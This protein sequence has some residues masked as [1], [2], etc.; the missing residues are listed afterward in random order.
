MKYIIKPQTE[1]SFFQLLPQN[2]FLL[3][4]VTGTTILIGTGVNKC[5][6]VTPLYHNNSAKGVCWKRVKDC[7]NWK[8]FGNCSEGIRCY[9]F[10]APS[11]R[12]RA[13]VC[14]EWA[15]GTCT[16]Q[17]DSR[18]CPDWHTSTPPQQQLELDFYRQG[19]TFLQI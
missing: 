10:H 12:G 14:S 17:T 1:I 11:K 6:I 7:P 16:Y 3:N 18:K 2:L 19:S 15:Q 4:Y 9:D 8:K 13:K 5:Y